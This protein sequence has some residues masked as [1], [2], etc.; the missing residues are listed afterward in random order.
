MYSLEIVLA[1]DTEVALRSDA[2]VD[3]AEAVLSDPSFSSPGEVPRGSVQGQ[4]YRL[5]VSLATPCLRSRQ[6]AA[7]ICL[8]FIDQNVC[9]GPASAA[10]R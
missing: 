10:I 9:H 8:L 7:G 4:A 3:D 2:L 1:T 6:H 5:P